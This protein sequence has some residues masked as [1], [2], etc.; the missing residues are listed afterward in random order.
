MGGGGR[1][2]A[3]IQAW[4]WHVTYLPFIAASVGIGNVIIRFKRLMKLLKFSYDDIAHPKSSP[5]LKNFPRPVVTKAWQSGLL[6]FR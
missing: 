5:L 1:Q 6:K 4:Q 3:G 2:M